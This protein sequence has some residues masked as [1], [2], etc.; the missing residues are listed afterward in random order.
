MKRNLAPTFGSY[1]EHMLNKEVPG[2][3]PKLRSAN[4]QVRVCSMRPIL[5]SFTRAQ[6]TWQ[7]NRDIASYKGD[8]PLK[9]HYDFLLSLEKDYGKDHGDKD[10]FAA[11]LEETLNSYW[12]VPK[13]KN[14]PR[15]ISL[16]ITF[17][18]PGKA[19]EWTDFQVPVAYFEPPDPRCVR[20]Y[21]RDRPS[22]QT[23]KRSFRSKYERNVMNDCSEEPKTAIKQ[24]LVFEDPQSECRLSDRMKDVAVSENVSFQPFGG[25]K[26]LFPVEQAEN[27][28]K[29]TIKILKFA[30]NEKNA[31][32]SECKKYPH[33]LQGPIPLS[34]SKTSGSGTCSVTEQFET[35]QSVAPLVEP[36]ATARPSGSGRIILSFDWLSDPTVTDVKKFRNPNFSP[37]CRTI[38]A[39]WTVN[40]EIEITYAVQARPALWNV[41]SREYK[42]APLKALMWAEVD[43]RRLGSQLYIY[44]QYYKG[45]DRPVRLGCQYLLLADWRLHEGHH[46]ERR[47]EAPKKAY[48][49][50]GSIVIVLKSRIGTEP[51]KKLFLIHIYSES[52]PEQVSV[53]PCV[54]LSQSKSSSQSDSR[55]SYLPDTLHPRSLGHRPD[56]FTSS[57][58]GKWKYCNRP[59]TV[60]EILQRLMDQFRLDPIEK[61]LPKQWFC[62]NSVCFM[63]KPNMVSHL[64]YRI[65][66]ECAITAYAA[67]MLRSAERM[68]R[69]EC[70]IGTGISISQIVPMSDGTYVGLVGPDAP[71]DGLKLPPRRLFVSGFMSRGDCG[72][73]KERLFSR[74][75]PAKSKTKP[76]KKIKHQKARKHSSAAR[77]RDRRLLNFRR[78]YINWR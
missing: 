61:T 71:P 69:W 41:A 11:N 67:K 5:V 30:Q 14:D 13:Y 68:I 24:Q 33:I 48:Q 35:E 66:S 60:S 62:F 9:L 47:M 37:P 23:R 7:L 76:K 22:N 53:C 56:C 54:R 29:F 55:S 50:N 73:T 31:T 32:F 51:Q 70:R 38:V 77:I 65:D 74:L 63:G 17:M 64:Q 27:I 15:L 49:V 20:M 6:F 59:E 57:S 4:R 12:D 46:E 28:E 19:G 16:L 58:K 3:F 78:R 40:E 34:G 43:T 75:R 39:S 44:V 10:V 72:P 52:L 36:E 21:P 42:Q 8:D 18:N 1:K 26:P 2:E 45:I 25:I